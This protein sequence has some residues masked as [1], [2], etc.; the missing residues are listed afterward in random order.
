MCTRHENNE[1]VPDMKIM[2]VYLTWKKWMFT[3]H[4]NNECVP[5]MKKMNVYLTWKYKDVERRGESQPKKK[6]I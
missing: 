6:F 2:N 5:D 3:W 4:E 1:C